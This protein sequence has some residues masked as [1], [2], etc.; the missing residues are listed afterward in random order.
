M[1]AG[2]E[3]E[4]YLKPAG[5]SNL[6]LRKPEAPKAARPE[7]VQQHM[8]RRLPEETVLLPSQVFTKAAPAA[9]DAAELN[10][11]AERVY[12]VLEKKLAIRKD[13]RGLR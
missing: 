7:P 9:M 5:S 11:L 10:L 1:S 12:Q 4:E 6:V 2:P 3:H 8:E 13:R